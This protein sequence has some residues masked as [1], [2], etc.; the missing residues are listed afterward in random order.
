MRLVQIGVGSGGIAVLDALARDQRLTHVTVADPDTFEAHNASRHLFGPR[1]A[2]RPKVEL[3][4]DWLADIRP[5]LAVEAWPI[6]AGGPAERP[7]LLAALALADVAVCA[8]DREPA[9]YACDELFRAAKKPWTLGE[10]LSGGVAGWAHRFTP[11]GACYGC[12]ASRLGRELPA[13]DPLHPR[14]DYAQPGAAAP[15]LT[16]AASKAS[17]LATAALHAL[18]TLDLLA[19]GGAPAGSW[20]LPLAEVPGVFPERFRGRKF[21]TPRAPN[22]L[23]C[24]VPAPGGDLDALVDAALTRLG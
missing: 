5:D 10:V 8:V 7:R 4:R 21:D 23:I 20:L 12:V 11:G 2:G 13:G 6:A 1:C 14:A 15:E 3:A 19:D 18:V 9:K 22:C 24:G 16:V 17:I